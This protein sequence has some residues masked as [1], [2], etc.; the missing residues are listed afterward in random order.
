M[1]LFSIVCLLPLFWIEAESSQPPLPSAPTLG[2]QFANETEAWGLAHPARRVVWGDLDGDGW[3]DCI[4]DARRV[5]LS[6]PA[7]QSSDPGRSPAR[8]FR[9]FTEESGLLAHPSQP[10]TARERVSSFLILADVDGDHDLDI[11]SGYSQEPERWKGDPQDETKEL[12]DAEGNRVPLRPDD[13]LR[14]EI[15]L[16]DGKGHFE[17]LSG[18]GVGNYAESSTCATFVDFDKDG[19]LDLF[20]GQWYRSYP[21]TYDAYPDRLYR[22]LGGGHFEEVTEAAGLLTARP[23]GRRDSS[24]PTYGVTSGDWN[25]DG[26]PDLFCCSYGRQWNRLWR[27]NRDGT[28][29]DVSEVTGF[30]GDEDR[31][32]VYPATRKRAPELPFRAN[33]NTF[34]CALADHDNDG[35]LDLFLGEITHAW[36]GSSSD[37]S[38]L[39]VNAGASR[40]FQF[41]R[42][43]DPGLRRSHER[44]DWNQGDIHVGWIDADGD[45]LEDLLIASS[46]YEDD[47]RLRLFHQRHDHSFSEATFRFGIDWPSCGAPS[48]G[49]F[50]NDGDPDLLCGRSLTRLDPDRCKE[51]GS[52][53]GLWVNRGG[54]GNWIKLQLVGRGAGGANT[55]GI[56]ARIYLKTHRHRLVREVFGGAGHA[57]HQNP[58]EV[59]FGLGS[60]Q[61]A[62]E[63][64]IAW[65][66]A[67]GLES[68]LTAIP[69]GV[70]LRVHEPASSQSRVRVEL[71]TFSQ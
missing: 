71:R 22:G 56:G 41:R 37:R 45:G 54:T 14:S 21:W 52:H 31:S 57:G 13:G 55:Q 38:S 61:L 25:N 49:D 44:E 8:Q 34:D 9:E 39:L 47:Q 1:T 18:S 19:V 32:G 59:C 46:D 68:R 43:G 15:L 20:V 7:L 66:N 53:A 24:R 17:R 3:L 30:D 40:D 51:L 33:G 62:Q 16:N 2:L 28:F 35:D 48:V 69:A 50:D 36:A 12:R 23:P 64:R 67:D 10:G 27:N 26:W 11:F 60:S 29:T 70:S 42:S 63:I 5:F 4:L 65:P 58:T 6:R